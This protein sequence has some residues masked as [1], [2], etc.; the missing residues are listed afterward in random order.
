MKKVLISALLLIGAPIQTWA[1][2]VYGSLKI[3]GQPVE[4][5]VRVEINCSGRPFAGQ[6]DQYGAYRINVIEGGRCDLKV[7]YKGREASSVVYSSDKP[8]RYD[9]DLVLENGRYI[10][11][12]R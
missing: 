2:P 4:A 1:A 5:G 6:T 7:R 12:R 8:V 9:F 3:N 11:R 10:L